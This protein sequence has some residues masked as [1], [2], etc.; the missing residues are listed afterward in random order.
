MKR[1]YC[2]EFSDKNEFAKWVVLMA[3]SCLVLCR[4][5]VKRYRE[6][7]LKFA[8]QWP[9]ASLKRLDVSRQ[10][11]DLMSC[12]HRKKDLKDKISSL[13]AQLASITD[14]LFSVSTQGK[15]GRRYRAVQTLRE[16]VC[17]LEQDAELWNKFDH[18]TKFALFLPLRSK[19]EMQELLRLL[20]QYVKTVW[21]D[22]VERVFLVMQKYLEESNG[23][24]ALRRDQLIA[25]EFRALLNYWSCRKA[26]RHLKITCESRAERV[27][28]EVEEKSERLQI[29]TGPTRT[30]NPPRHREQPILQ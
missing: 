14:A 30:P 1:S 13:R 11:I 29:Y 8:G 19:H 18:A 9:A 20:G 16:F 28:C 6:E 23:T 15:S 25:R 5:D 17:E 4:G 22:T 10:D 12:E 3:S 24:Y 21:C 2:L 7:L 26:V 27:F